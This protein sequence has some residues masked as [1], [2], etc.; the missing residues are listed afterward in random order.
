MGKT[1]LAAEFAREQRYHFPGGVL[2][3]EAESE[4]GLGAAVLRLA[5]QSLALIDAEG[6]DADDAREALVAW[7][8]DAAHGR[9]LLVLDNVDDPRAEEW[10]AAIPPEYRTQ[11]GGSVP[12]LVR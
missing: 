2:W 9:T 5:T 1:T 10:L 12:W 7:L 8:A 6:A 3:L 11:R 4:A